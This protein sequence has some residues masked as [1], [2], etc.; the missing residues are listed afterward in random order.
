MRVSTGGVERI[1][2]GLVVELWVLLATSGGCQQTIVGHGMG[3]V[4]PGG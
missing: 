1:S 4:R 3:F 2:D